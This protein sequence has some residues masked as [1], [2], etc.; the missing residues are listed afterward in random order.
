MRTA[1]STGCAASWPSPGRANRGRSTSSATPRSSHPCQET[2]GSSSPRCS[3]RDG[4]PS[5]DET[6]TPCEPFVV[7]H[8]SPS[9]PERA[10]S[11][12][13]DSPVIRGSGTPSTT[14]RASPC[15]TIVAAARSTRPCDNAV[16]A[17]HVPSARSAIGCS[18]SPA[19]C[20]ATAPNL[21]PHWKSPPHAQARPATGGRSSG[22]SPGLNNG[23][24]LPPGLRG[25]RVGAGHAQKA[26]WQPE[27]PRRSNAPRRAWLAS[28]Q[29]CSWLRA[30]RGPAKT[31]RTAQ[32]AKDRWASAAAARRRRAGA[33]GCLLSRQRSHGAISA[34]PTRGSL[35]ALSAG[36]L[37]GGCACAPGRM[38][39]LGRRE[40]TYDEKL[41]RH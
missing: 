33:R 39:V 35:F 24:A 21:T 5:S 9:V 37:C 31:N 41:P 40:E 2:V 28:R 32:T 20:F 11:S 19:R 25:I 38:P 10:V 7:P 27:N 17:T 14:G 18:M 29:P 4:K 26:S 22:L 15:S 1:S 16:T 3:Q 34:A 23:A 36:M 13:D 6:I 30:A 8:R 12:R